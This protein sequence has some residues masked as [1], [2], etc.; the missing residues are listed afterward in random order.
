MNTMTK[1]KTL[2]LTFAL[3]VGLSPFV[4]CSSTPTGLDRALSTVTTNYVPMLALQTNVV[5]V[6]NTNVVVQTVTAT[7]IQGVMIPIFVTNT[8]SVVSYVTNIVVAT[9]LIPVY[10]ETANTNIAGA[11]SGAGSVL[12][13]FLPG[14]GTVVSTGLL[15][16]LS[17][18][19][20]VRNRQYSGQNDALS[21]S[22]GVLA[23]IIETGREVMSQSPQGQAAAN[24]FTQ[25]MVTHQADT[26]T[27][28]TISQIVKAATNNTEAQAAAGQIL[29]LINQTPPPGP[30]AAPVKTA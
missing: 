19:L 20:G 8:T 10:S 16:V 3:L 30:T 14:I 1:I 23:Q 24:A 26:N 21:Q 27:I 22:A 11:I 5:T 28:A 2:A 18:F 13:T 29:G 4:G 17:I 7:N 6:Y 25:W 9:N 12:N 15:G